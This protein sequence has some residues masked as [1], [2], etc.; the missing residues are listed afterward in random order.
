MRHGQTSY[1][2]KNLING[3]VKKRI[4]ITKLGRQQTLEATRKLKNV[5]FDVIFI[6]EFWRTKQTAE[7][8]NKYYGLPFIID[9]RINEINMGFEGKDIEEYR[10]IKNVSKVSKFRFKINGRESFSDLKIR[11]GKFLNDLKKEN[12]ENVLVIT[13]E[14]VVQMVFS[15]LNG[16]SGEEAMGINIGN[17]EILKFEIYRYR[18]LE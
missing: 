11:V 7:I 1:N 18:E 9:Y 15:I 14:S 12:Y 10:A 17:C 13:H 4:G 2:V 3:D 16:L 6:S 8:I 5:K